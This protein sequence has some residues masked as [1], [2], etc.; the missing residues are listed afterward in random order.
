MPGATAS[1]VR[2]ASLRWSMEAGPGRWVLAPTPPLTRM[3]P[4]SVFARLQFLHLDHEH[5]PLS[6]SITQNS[7]EEVNRCAPIDRLHRCPTLGWNPSSDH[8]SFCDLENG[9]SLRFGRHFFK[10]CLFIWLCWVLVAARGIVVGLC[11]IF[12]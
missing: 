4:I 7:T 11:G 5:I 6:A 8:L 2:R 1:P 3:S 12:C 10:M 9:A